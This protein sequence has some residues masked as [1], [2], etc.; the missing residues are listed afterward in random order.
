MP[1]VYWCGTAKRVQSPV[2]FYHVG[3]GNVG[4]IGIKVQVFLA[5]ACRSRDDRPNNGGYE[6]SKKNRKVFYGMRFVVCSFTQQNCCIRYMEE[7]SMRV[8]I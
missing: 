5:L 1:S 4:S 8:E 7:F 2:G 3:I 6:L